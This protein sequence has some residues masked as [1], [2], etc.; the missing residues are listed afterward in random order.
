M[1]DPKTALLV[2]GTWVVAGFVVAVVSVPLVRRRSAGVAWG[3]WALLV[4]PVFGAGVWYVLTHP[5]G[6]PLGPVYHVLLLA[7]LTV[8]PTASAVWTASVR[9]VRE[10]QDP[11][12]VDLLLA[13]FT[14][15]AVLFI[16]VLAGIIPDLMTVIGA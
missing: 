15:V 10:P 6:L 4:L 14:Y 2:L 9:A 8:T 7:L 13:G 12:W 3:V 16:G 5:I 1:T 11:V